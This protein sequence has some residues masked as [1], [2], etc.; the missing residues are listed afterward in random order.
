M[1]LS[2]GTSLG[3]YEILGPVG[4]EGMGE[5][6]RAKDPRLEREVAIK[7]LPEDVATDPER[8][9]RFEKEAKAAGLA[10]FFDIFTPDAAEM[11]FL[12]DPNATHPAYVR[13]MMYENME[14]MPELIEAADEN[15]NAAEA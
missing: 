14:R 15:R 5:V 7:V 12:A 3:P 9:R 4:A 2:P 13:F 8:L 6:Y 11:A 1:A 10:P